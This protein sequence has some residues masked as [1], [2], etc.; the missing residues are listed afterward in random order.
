MAN[1]IKGSASGTPNAVV[2]KATTSFLTAGI[3]STNTHIIY[4]VDDALQSYKPDRS[5]NGISGFESGQGYYMIAKVDMDLESVLVPPISSSSQLATP[6][7]FLATPA[8][9][10]QINISWGSVINATGYVLQRATNS[11]FTTGLFTLL[12]NVNLTSYNDTGLDA[13]TTYYYRVLAKASGYTDS[14]YATGNGTTLGAS[15]DADAQALFT[16][17][18]GAGGTI[19]GG[20]KTKVN[21]LFIGLKAQ[22]LYT[23]MKALYLYLGGNAAGASFNAV[24][25]TSDPGSFKITWTGTPTFDSV[26]GFTPSSGNYGVTNFHPDAGGLTS[27]TGAAMGF[28]NTASIANE[29]T[30]GLFSWFYFAPQNDGTNGYA[31]LSGSFKNGAAQAGTGFHMATREPA[32]SNI[33]S[34][35]DGSLVIN[36]TETFLESYAGDSIGSY[37]LVGG[38]KEHPS[39]VYPSTTPLK[40]SFFSEGLTSTQAG[41]LN[42]LIQAYI[43]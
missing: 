27:T 7:S 22:S 42:T 41:N 2:A 28:V 10:S 24:N 11:I 6:G 31:R 13:S 17:V 4:K 12:N 20:Q 43:S 19:S 26:A 18:E 40:M 15:Y 1:N 8:S 37:C 32:T 9:S 36:T 33:K 21:N 25:P 3:N 16:A 30:M 23:K 39:T 5:I 34:Y 35:K 14:G 38:M 29:Y